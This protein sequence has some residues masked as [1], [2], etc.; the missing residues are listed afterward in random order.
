MVAQQT[1]AAA[2]RHILAV[3]CKARQEA[4]KDCMLALK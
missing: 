3:V 1:H 2:G 4:Q